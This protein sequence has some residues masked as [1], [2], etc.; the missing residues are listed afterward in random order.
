MEKGHD[1]SNARKNPFADKVK[2]GYDVI[3]HYNTIEQGSDGKTKKVTKTK[4]YSVDKH[5]KA[6][7]TQPVDKRI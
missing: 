6:T 4:I 3:I 1:F 5:E 2:N 7:V